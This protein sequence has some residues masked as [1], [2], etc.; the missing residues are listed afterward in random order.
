M[1]AYDPL[2][3]SMAMTYEMKASLLHYPY[4]GGARSSWRKRT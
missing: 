1:K 3:I 4:M 2:F